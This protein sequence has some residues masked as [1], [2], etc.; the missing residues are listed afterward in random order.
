MPPETRF[1]IMAACIY[2]PLGLGYASRRVGLLRADASKAISRT[3]VLTLESA[4]VLVGC[5]HLDLASP[6]RALLVPLIGALVSVGLLGAGLVGSA[7]F[8]HE[9][10]QRGAFLLCALMSNIGMTLGG[11]LCYALFGM[12]GQSLAV[13]YTSH[14]LPVALLIGLMI[15]THYTTG[16]RAS[17]GAT[18]AGMARNPLVVVPNLALV[19]GV[20]LNVAG[21]RPPGWVGPANGIGVHAVVCL[22][23]YAIGLTL[24]LSRV[25]AYWREVAVI[26]FTKF[27]VGPLLGAG[28][29]VLLGQWGAFDGLLWRVVVVEGAMPVAIFA[30]IV[31]NLFDLDRDLANSAWVL[32]TLG[33]AAIIPVLYLLTA[34]A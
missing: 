24:R 13:A 4:V 34:A 10:R 3:V 9:G 17:V 6:G 19:A 12:P 27:A 2:L 8:R 29:V 1:A 14:F 11:F 32:T 31:S 18:L 7:F 28:V 26:A 25:A 15:A 22:H 20:A 5:W 21:A 30:T 23:A 33:C 16:T